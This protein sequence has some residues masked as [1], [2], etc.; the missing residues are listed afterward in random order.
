MKGIGK[1]ILRQIVLLR[2]VAQVAKR[3]SA[4]RGQGLKHCVISHIILFINMKILIITLFAPKANINRILLIIRKSIN[5]NI[6]Q[7]A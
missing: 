2:H 5:N 3:R 1:Y 7:K 6:L 4:P